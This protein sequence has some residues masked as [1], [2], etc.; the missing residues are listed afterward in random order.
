[1]YAKHTRNTPLVLWIRKIFIRDIA[2]AVRIRA[3]E[4]GDEAL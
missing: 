3:N 1:M 4:R 2:Q